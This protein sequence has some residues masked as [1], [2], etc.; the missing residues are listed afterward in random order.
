MEMKLFVFFFFA[1]AS[2]FSRFHEN[3][4]KQFKQRFDRDIQSQQFVKLQEKSAVNFANVIS[5]G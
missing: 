1:E 3:E 2:Q 5:S 4:L